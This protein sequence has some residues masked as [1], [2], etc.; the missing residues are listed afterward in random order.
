MDMP[1]PG[2]A[3]ERLKAFV[4]EWRGQEKMHPTPWMPEG[5]MRD[6]KI[7]NR[8]ALDG[9]AVVQDYMQLDN[10]K[11]AFQGHAV[12]MANQKGDAYQMHWFDSFSPSLFEGSFDGKKAVFTHKSP[13]GFNRASFDFSKPGAYIFKME[14]SQDGKTWS[15]MMDGEYQKA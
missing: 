12:I 1:K 9:F 15:P 3:Q 5:G 10:G 7:S 2:P 8:L 13:M 14:M 4:G 11:P 6:A